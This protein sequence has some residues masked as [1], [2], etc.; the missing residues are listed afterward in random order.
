M[1]RMFNPIPSSDSDIIGLHPDE[2][3]TAKRCVHCI[4]QI[5]GYPYALPAIDYYEQTLD[6]SQ[7][8]FSAC[9]NWIGMLARMGSAAGLD[10]DERQAICGLVCKSGPVGDYIN[11][12]H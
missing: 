6:F 1:N 9:I 11:S 2:I 8:D 4:E 3:A 5:P 12:H 10:N 7:L